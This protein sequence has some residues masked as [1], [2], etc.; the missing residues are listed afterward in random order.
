MIVEA[1]TESEAHDRLLDT[2]QQSGDF[3]VT[4][5]DPNPERFSR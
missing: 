2:I 4:Q 3:L 1:P 5:T